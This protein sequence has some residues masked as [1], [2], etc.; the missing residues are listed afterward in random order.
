MKDRFE[1][2]I[3]DLYSI[4]REMVRAS[5]F[6]EKYYAMEAERDKWRDKYQELLNSSMN[7]NN[8]MMNNLLEMAINGVG[9]KSAEQVGK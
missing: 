7:H 3:V 6:E 1:M 8:A 5:Q 9:S 2:P 4:G